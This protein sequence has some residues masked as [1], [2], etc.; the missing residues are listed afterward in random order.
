MDW[1]HKVDCCGADLA[2]GHGDR[3]EAL[4]SR[5]ATKAREVGAD[6]IVVCCGL[7]HANLDMRQ[8]AHGLPILYITEVLGEALQVPG[9]AT[10]WRK[11]MTDPSQLFG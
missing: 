4:C 3:V 8:G 9:R 2:L 10:W 1:S 6:A 5:I 7:C 11:H